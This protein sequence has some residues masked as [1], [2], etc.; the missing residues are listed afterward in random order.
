MTSSDSKKRDYFSIEVNKSVVSYDN[1]EKSVKQ[2]IV[3]FIYFP[4][5]ALL[6]YKWVQIL[7]LTD[8][9]RERRIAA[10]PYLR[11][12]ILDVGCGPINQVK[13]EYS[14]STI[15]CD[16][17]NWGNLDTV[18]SAENLAFKDHSFDSVLMLACLNH[19]SDKSKALSEA[20]R[21]LKPGGRL[22]LTMTSKFVGTIVHLAVSWFDYDHVRGMDSNEEFGLSKKTIVKYFKDSGFKLLIDKGFVYNLNRVYVARKNG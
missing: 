2:S 12:L 21:V 6:P 4:L 19:F 16:V 20:Y 17:Y 13:K 5:R 8:L 22:I 14:G 9:G 10:I 1:A 11:G 18:C 15:T 3:D 7:H